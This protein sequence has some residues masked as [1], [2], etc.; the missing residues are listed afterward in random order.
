M[1]AAEEAHTLQ[2]A[3]VLW[4]CTT[5]FIHV[6]PWSRLE[7]WLKCGRK[8]KHI[9]THILFKQEKKVIIPGWGYDTYVFFLDKEK[10]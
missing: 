9:H 4:I 3:T 7:P 1:P 8:E 5:Q 2:L 10:D 6:P